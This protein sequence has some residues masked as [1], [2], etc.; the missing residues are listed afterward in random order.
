MADDDMVDE[1]FQEVEPEPEPERETSSAPREK[2]TPRAKPA[3]PASHYVSSTIPQPTPLKSKMVLSDFKYHDSY[4]PDEAPHITAASSSK[5]V[6]VKIISDILAGDFDHAL[7]FM[8]N[9]QV[10]C[11][12]RALCILS[13]CYAR[14]L[15]AI[16]GR[17]LFRAAQR[18]EGQALRAR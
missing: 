18:H 16:D 10:L 7:Q 13:L 1:D 15:T 4:F 3:K 2:R 14:Q 11:P 12:P 8:L 5:D 17:A 9:N 6:T